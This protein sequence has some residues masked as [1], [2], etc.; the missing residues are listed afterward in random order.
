MYFFNLLNLIIEIKWWWWWIFSVESNSGWNH[1]GKCG[2]PFKILSN[3]G[4]VSFSHPD[5]VHQRACSRGLILWVAVPVLRTLT[6]QNFVSFYRTWFNDLKFCLEPVLMCLT[7]AE[8]MS[9]ANLRV[10]ICTLVFVTIK[11]HLLFLYCLRFTLEPTIFSLCLVTSCGSYCFMVS[12]LSSFSV[13]FASSVSLTGSYTD[14]VSPAS[15]GRNW[16]N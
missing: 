16:E 10:I 6:V 11:S 7:L 13:C 5:L 12:W 3:A 15:R 9:I 1:A 2:P 8:L 4:R 14:R